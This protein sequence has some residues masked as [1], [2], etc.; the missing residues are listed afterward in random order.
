MSLAVSASRP[1]ASSASSP[2]VAVSGVGTGQRAHPHD[3]ASL[4]AVLAGGGPGDLRRRLGVDG[5]Q[6]RPHGVDGLAPFV[7]LCRVDEVRDGVQTHHLGRA[8]AEHLL[9]AGG[10]ERD[11]P[12][13]VDAHDGAA[14]GGA[15]E[16]LEAVAGIVGVAGVAPCDAGLLRE[17]A[18]KRPVP[19]DH[20]VD[21]R[22]HERGDGRH[23]RHL[24]PLERRVLGR[25]DN[26]EGDEQR[27][28]QAEQPDEEVQAPPVEREPH[29]GQEVDDHQPGVG[30][31]LSVTDDGDDRDVADRNDQPG[32]IRQPLPGQQERRCDEHEEQDA[33]ERDLATGV[34]GEGDH[35]DEHR[36]DGHQG[37][38]RQ[39]HPHRAG[40]A[41]GQ[42]GSGH[43]RFA[44]PRGVGLV[45]GR[46]AHRLRAR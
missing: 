30:T 44:T 7:D 35:G 31:T 37:E 34:M 2:S 23:D 12:G 17:V 10:E 25:A 4:L 36:A 20:G 22:R 29:D 11:G 28:V 13:R 9:G 5:L 38:D 32:P 45:S 43:R 46:L 3:A 24:A 33:G 14:G 40:E 21:G 26:E 16:G 1:S 15:Q 41:D 8:V 18:Q 27:Q 42:G 19:R 6:R 39:A